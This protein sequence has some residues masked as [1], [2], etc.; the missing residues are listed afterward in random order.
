MMMSSTQIVT[1]DKILRRDDELIQMGY[2][3][4]DLA[5]IQITGVSCFTKHMA[6]HT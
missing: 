1:N 5:T 3:P 4:F 6:I 2:D